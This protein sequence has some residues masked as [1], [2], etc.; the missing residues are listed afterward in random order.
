MPFIFHR[1]HSVVCSHTYIA[2][3]SN[4]AVALEVTVAA[5]EVTVAAREVTVAARE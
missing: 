4:G 2:P 3:L 5:R 1:R